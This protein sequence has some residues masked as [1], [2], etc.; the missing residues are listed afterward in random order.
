MDPKTKN[1]FISYSREL[2][3]L[4][5]LTPEKRRVV[6]HT[7]SPRAGTVAVKVECIMKLY[8]TLWDISLKSD[9]SRSYILVYDFANMNSNL[10]AT[11]LSTWRLMLPIFM[12]KY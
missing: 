8:T 3:P 7:F 2:L 9:T 5:K 4:P 1:L 6:I 10:A 12:V 11:I